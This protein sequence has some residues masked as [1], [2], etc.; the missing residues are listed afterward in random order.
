LEKEEKT[1][2]LKSRAIWIKEGDNNSMS[3]HQYANFRKNVDTIWE[4]KAPNKSLAPS[5]NDKAEERVCYFHDLFQASARCPIQKILDV[6]SKFDRV[7][8]GDVNKCLLEEVTEFKVHD[9]LFS[10]QNEIVRIRMVS[11]WNSMWVFKT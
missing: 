9:A 11:Q 5:F 7:F 3:F 6:I 1:C 2:H 8:K 10:M 4:V